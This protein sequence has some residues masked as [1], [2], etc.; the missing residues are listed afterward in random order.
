MV[1]SRK[2]YIS[3]RCGDRCYTGTPSRY[4]PDFKPLI[5]I[6]LSVAVCDVKAS[7]HTKSSSS[8]E[9]GLICA[10][11]EIICA[12]YKNTARKSWF[13]YHDYESAILKRYGVSH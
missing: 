11:Y 3:H 8:V 1:L 13:C 5:Y 10:A 6:H 4:R 7:I 9:K 12:A 2:Q